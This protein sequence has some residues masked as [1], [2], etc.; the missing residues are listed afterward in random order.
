MPRYACMMKSLAIG[1]Q[2]KKY[3]M[4]T[5]VAAQTLMEKL[6]SQTKKKNVSK[7]SQNIIL[8]L[9]RAKH[10]PCAT[11]DSVGRPLRLLAIRHGR[12]VQNEPVLCRISNN[13]I[14]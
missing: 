13:L 1:G 10:G 8:V 7:K 9:V 4:V 6:A 14:L 2:E 12:E 5:S 3:C 11:E